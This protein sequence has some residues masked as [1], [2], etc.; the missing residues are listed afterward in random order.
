MSSLM[1]FSAVFQIVSVLTSLLSLS[2]AMVAYE[3]ANRWANPE[4][5][6]VSHIGNFVQFCWR[7]FMVASRVLALASFA[8]VFPVM[9][10]ALGGGHWILMTL[11]I[12]MMVS[13]HESKDDLDD[14]E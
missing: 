11:W 7:F 10:F 2:W 1:S 14:L 5:P 6:N 12:I 13:W 4:K 3:S 8:T 9:L